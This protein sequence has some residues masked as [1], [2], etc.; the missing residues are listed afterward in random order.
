MAGDRQGIGDAN[1]LRGQRRGGAWRTAVLVLAVGL[2]HAGRP[3]AA[4]EPAVLPPGDRTGTIHGIGPGGMQVKLLSSGRELWVARA[5]DATVELTGTAAREMLAPKQFV[6]VAVELDDTGK[7]SQPV[8]KVTFPGGGTPGV[9]AAGI[10]GAE[11]KARRPAGKRPAGSYLVAGFIKSA[12][13]DGF[14]VQVGRDRFEIELA[15][16]AELEV[17]TPNLAVASVGDGV[18]LEGKL[19]QENQLLASSIKVTLAN[20][21][22]PPQKGKRRPAAAP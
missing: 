3:S 4:Q 16:E 13:G 10:G 12:D 6:Q 11:P 18:E 22:T 1:L 21:L 2:V 14:V 9:T 7:V 5:P 15:P 8:D 19:V 20:P 17:R